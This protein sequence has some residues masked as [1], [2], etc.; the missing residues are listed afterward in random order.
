MKIF[1]KSIPVKFIMLR[2]SLFNA[3]IIDYLGSILRTLGHHP[4]KTYSEGM[5]LLSYLVGI[6]FLTFFTFEMSSMYCH[7]I[8]NFKTKESY[9]TTFERG[10]REQIYEGVKM[11]AVES[12]YFCRC[13]NFFFL[14]RMLIVIMLIFNAQYMQVFQ[15]FGSL[16]IMT[17]FT[18]AT[19]YYSKKFDFFK[20]KFTKIFRLIQEVSMT[21]LVTLINTFYFNNNFQILTHDIKI[22]FVMF[23]IL[24]LIVNILLEIF[25]AF[26]LFIK[27]LKSKN[28]KRRPK[29]LALEEEREKVSSANKRFIPAEILVYPVV[30]K[31]VKGKVKKT[32][33]G[34][35]KKM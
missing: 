14:F 9:L 34:Q 7:C 10:I 25:N 11:S 4:T 16:A 32:K 20:S 2:V 33:N 26:L 21:L 12:S 8:S 13:Y 28:K 19:F 5:G 1:H 35:R 17:G 27:I 30:K 29:N 24:L 23:F 31:K 18:I 3:L 22:L 6:T 15:V